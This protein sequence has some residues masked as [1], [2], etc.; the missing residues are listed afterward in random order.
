MVH[1]VLSCIR[2]PLKWLCMQGLAVFLSTEQTRSVIYVYIPCQHDRISV[3]CMAFRLIGFCV[4]FVVLGLSSLYCSLKAPPPFTFFG[5]SHVVPIRFGMLQN[6]SR[7][8]YCICQG[9]LVHSIE[10]THDPTIPPTM[11]AQ[12]TMICIRQKP[13]INMVGYI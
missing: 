5:R 12:Q 3:C 11:A 1:F 2:T 7:A 10:C 8:Q 4:M 6:T 9:I 13:G